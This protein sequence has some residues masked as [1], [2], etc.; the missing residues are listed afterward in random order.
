MN[1]LIQPSNRKNKKFM[2]LDKNG[3]FIHFGYKPMSDYTQHKD[4]K[5]RKN[6]YSRHYGI[7]N[8]TN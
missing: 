5:R 4:S 2:F 1:N 7:K 6:Y 3:N 8:I